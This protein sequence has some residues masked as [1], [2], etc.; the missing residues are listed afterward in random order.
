[1]RLPENARLFVG[2]LSPSTGAEDLRSHFRRYGEVTSICLPKDRI[3]GRPRCFAFV[4]FSR[5]RD[6]ACALAYPHHVINGRQVYIGKA[7]PIQF[8]R[9]FVPLCDRILRSGNKCYRVGDKIKITIGPFPDSYEEDEYVNEV[10][11]YGVMVNNTLIYYCIIGYISV[12]GKEFLVRWPPVQ[13]DDKSDKFWCH[14]SIKPAYDFRLQALAEMS[15]GNIASNEGE[16]SADS[17]EEA[18]PQ[19]WCWIMHRRR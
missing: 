7:E 10:K 4:Q 11:K 14:G 9:T 1:M 18:R 16:S 3:T 15:R 2:G 6:A 19:N 13:G 12:D 5:P 8:K 17:P